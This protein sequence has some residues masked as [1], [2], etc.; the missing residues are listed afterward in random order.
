[1][2]KYPNNQPQNR[3]QFFLHLSLLRPLRRSI[4]PRLS[5]H[6]AQFVENPIEDILELDKGIIYVFLQIEKICTSRNRKF[7]SKNGK[8]LISKVHF[9]RV[10]MIEGRVIYKSKTITC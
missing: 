5:S 10:S 7:W 3:I 8:I 4:L 6:V 2:K 1:M 9:S